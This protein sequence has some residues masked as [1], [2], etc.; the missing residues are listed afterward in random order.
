VAIADYVKPLVNGMGDILTIK[1]AV[2]KIIRRLAHGASGQV[3]SLLDEIL[4]PLEKEC[5]RPINKNDP[6]ARTLQM[7]KAA[8]SAVIAL[9]T[10]PNATGHAKLQEV[11]SKSV[12]GGPFKEEYAELV[13]VSK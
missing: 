12:M 5:K 3:F 8:L 9:N 10:I 2:Y 4:P 11:V 13:K 6:Q 7:K 1:E